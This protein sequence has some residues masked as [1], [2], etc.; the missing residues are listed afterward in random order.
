MT[1]LVGI[2]GDGLAAETTEIV[3]YGIYALIAYIFGESAVDIAR[4]TAE[5]MKAIM[6][7]SEGKNDGN[8]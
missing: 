6:E 3:R 5:K 4:Q 2:F 8:A 7:Q 1:I